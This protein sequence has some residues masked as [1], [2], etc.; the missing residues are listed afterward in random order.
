MWN[1]VGVRRVLFVFFLGCA[2]VTATPGFVAP[3]R[4][5]SVC[6]ET[7][8]L[9]NTLEFGREN[10]S[11]RCLKGRKHDTILL[12]RWGFGHSFRIFPGRCPW[13][14]HC[15]PLAL[16][17]WRPVLI[18]PPGSS[19]QTSFRICQSSMPVVK[20]TLERRF[21]RLHPFDSPL[22][23]CHTGK[24]TTVE[25]ASTQYFSRCL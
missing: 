9:C 2:V 15:V 6:L 11:R 21:T 22:H 19:P 7:M 5:G 20:S 24:L 23:A 3:P 16:N 10:P 25:F 1:P 8:S 14:S 13:L 17:T 18:V 12:P 4:W